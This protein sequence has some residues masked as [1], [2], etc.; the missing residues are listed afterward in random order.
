MGHSPAVCFVLT[1]LL[2]KYPKTH[3]GFACCTNC[4]DPAQVLYSDL[5]STHQSQFQA[6]SGQH[7]SAI[8]I[9]V[10]GF[11]GSRCSPFGIAYGGVVSSSPVLFSCAAA[12][13]S[14]NISPKSGRALCWDCTRLSPFALLHLPL[15]VSRRFIADRAVS[16]PG[17]LTRVP[18]PDLILDATCSNEVG[19]LEL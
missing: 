12:P 14:L 17:V 15:C 8:A 6:E 13:N 5:T 2:F 9:V 16:P 19:S 1:A 18:Q 11:Q 7:P 3:V 4:H 10:G